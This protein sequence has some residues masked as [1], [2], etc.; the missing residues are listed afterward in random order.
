[1]AFVNINKRLEITLTE[2]GK[3]KLITGGDIG[4]KYFSFSDDGVRYDVNNEPEIVVETQGNSDTTIYNG[5]K[6]PIIYKR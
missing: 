3:E 4:F 5:N 6:S 2:Y 1:M